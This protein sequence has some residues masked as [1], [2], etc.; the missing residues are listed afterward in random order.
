MGVGLQSHRRSRGWFHQSPVVP[1]GFRELGLQAVAASDFLI[2][3]ASW[4]IQVSFL[5]LPCL[6]LVA[7]VCSA[8]LYVLQVI[9][10]CS[11]SIFP[12]VSWQMFRNIKQN[13]FSPKP[14]SLPG[15]PYSQERNCLKTKFFLGVF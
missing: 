2:L 13:S 14:S 12:T 4:M 11:Y 6:Y 8:D 7:K 5:F 9:R 15:I 1:R 3:E 10:L